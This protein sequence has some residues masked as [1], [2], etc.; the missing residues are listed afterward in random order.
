MKEAG[1]NGNKDDA[2]GWLADRENEIRLE[3]GA[4]RIRPAR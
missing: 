1:V 4:E 3:L 2:K